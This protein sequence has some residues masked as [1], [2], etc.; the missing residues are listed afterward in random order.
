MTY[1]PDIAWIA[2]LVLVFIGLALNS[3]SL[4]IVVV[5]GILFF[6]GVL[7]SLFSRAHSVESNNQT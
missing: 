4:A 7:I 1:L 6:G 5:G 3:V 2:G